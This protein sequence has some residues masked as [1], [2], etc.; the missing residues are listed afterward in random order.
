[1]QLIGLRELEPKF[2]GPWIQ[3][4]VEPAYR[5]QGAGAKVPWT[6]TL[7]KIVKLIGLRK[8]EPRFLG[9][10]IQVR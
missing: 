5:P 8:L 7:G 10:W 6:M 4:S 1:M 9:P 2:L 3:V